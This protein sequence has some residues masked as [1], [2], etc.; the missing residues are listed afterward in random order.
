MVEPVSCP[1]RQETYERPFT[2][3]NCWSQ[4]VIARF[5]KRLGSSCERGHRHRP[6][7]CL[8]PQPD[9]VYAGQNN[10]S[11]SHNNDPYFGICYYADT[12]SP[13][14]VSPQQGYPNDGTYFEEPSEEEETDP[15]PLII[16]SFG[17]SSPT[18]GGSRAAISSYNVAEQSINPT[19]YQC[20]GWY[21]ESRPEL[22]VSND[23]SAPTR[24]RIVLGMHKVLDFSVAP[25]T[26]NTVFVGVNGVQGVVKRFAGTSTTPKLYSYYDTKGRIWTFFGYYTNSGA[27]VN[28]HGAK[29]QLWT[30]ADADGGGSKMYT[31]HA[32]DPASALSSGFV[33]PAEMPRHGHGRL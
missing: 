4:P 15:A 26:S 30:A 24:V 32:T 19:P 6:R 22:V 5:R 1:Q 11:K 16:C 23:E 17:D 10:D 9:A 21:Q 8:R 12:S 29:G 20:W 28:P 18:C 27:W 3:A 7:R 25:S 13:S 31:G 33:N 14:G 2:L